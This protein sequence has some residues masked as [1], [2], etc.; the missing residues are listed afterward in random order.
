LTL[1]SSCGHLHGGK[2]RKATDAR[3]EPGVCPVHGIALKRMLIP[4]HT[5]CTLPDEAYSVACKTNFPYA[6]DLFLEPTCMSEPVDMYICPRCWYEQQQ[7]LS[8]MAPRP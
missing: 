3:P 1:S 4:M 8:N 6:P 7:W 2:A 5:N